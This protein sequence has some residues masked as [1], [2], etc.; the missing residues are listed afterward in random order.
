M[1]LLSK[2]SG[3]SGFENLDPGAYVGRCVSVIDLGVQQTPFG[4][5]EKVYIAIPKV[6][7]ALLGVEATPALLGVG[8]ILGFRIASIMVAGST[9]SWLILIPLIAHLGRGLEQPYFPETVK[10]IAEM[11]ASEIWNRYIR[12]IGAGA[13]A[14]GG[15]ATIVRSIPT[16]IASFKLGLSEVT[17]PGR[18]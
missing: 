5:K 15:I 14:F 10:T 17:S 9:I 11:S 2:D 4:G 1:A 18:K 3:G 8:Y 6:K 13:V 7:K 12:Y 16:M